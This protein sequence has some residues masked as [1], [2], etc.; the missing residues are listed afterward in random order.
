MRILAA[1]VALMALA[2]TL[3]TTTSS[4]GAA[5]LA[6]SGPSLLAAPGQCP[7][8]TDRSL[9]ART[10]M[11]AMRCMINHARRAA[12]VTPLLRPSGQLAK[13][14]RRKAADILGC[15]DFSHTACGH[16]MA[17][18]MRGAGYAKGCFRVGENIAWGSGSQGTVRAIMRGWLNSP[19]HRRNLL[20]PRFRQQGVGVRVGTLEG[21]RG[22]A[23]WTHQLGARC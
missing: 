20:S 2:L 3:V 11:A 23:V 10:Q 17:A 13:A 4:A 18:R 19:P 21:T 22:A 14:A 15:R 16:A 5:P 6:A 7:G 1:A 8:Q 9:P 12:G